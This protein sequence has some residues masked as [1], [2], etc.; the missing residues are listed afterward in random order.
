MRVDYL[1]HICLTKA[2][3]PWF[4]EQNSGHF[5]NV[6]SA[7][8]VGVSIY[9]VVLQLRR[10]RSTMCSVVGVSHVILDVGI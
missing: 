8:G 7:A 2:V 6:S 9:A 5:V 10:W 1:G 3:L 4:I